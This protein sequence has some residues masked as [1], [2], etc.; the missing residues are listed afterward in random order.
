VLG[1]ERAEKSRLNH[2]TM[3]DI[4]WLLALHNQRTPLDILDQLSDVAKEQTVHHFIHER[5]QK[6]CDAQLVGAVWLPT[7]VD[8]SPAAIL[9]FLKNGR[10]MVSRTSWDNE[11][12]WFLDS[13]MCIHILHMYTIVHTYTNVWSYYVYIICMY[14][15]M[16]NTYYTI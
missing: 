7:L 8:P 1:L 3:L 9:S 2:L 16:Q 11:R 6:L 13:W 10:E 5:C 4:V 14:K 12:P 15:Y